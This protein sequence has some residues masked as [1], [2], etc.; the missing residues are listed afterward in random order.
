VV[1]ENR[2]PQAVEKS[3]MMTLD[4]TAAFLPVTILPAGIYASS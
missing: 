4:C 3:K 2:S 1:Q